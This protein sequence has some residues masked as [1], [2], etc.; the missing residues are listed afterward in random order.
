[1]AQVA[2]IMERHYRQK[3]YGITKEVAHE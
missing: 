1:M 2:K 3:H